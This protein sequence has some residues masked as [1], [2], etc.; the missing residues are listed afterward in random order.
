MCDNELIRPII[1]IFRL[2]RSMKERWYS[3]LDESG[4][5]IFWI[6]FL[7]IISL[8]SLL[9]EFTCLITLTWFTPEHTVFFSTEKAGNYAY[10]RLLLHYPS[11]KVILHTQSFRSRLSVI[12]T[13]TLSLIILVCRKNITLPYS[14]VV[15]SF[16]QRRSHRSHV[17]T[18][19]SVPQ[20]FS[21]DI[22]GL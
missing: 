1:S 9:S 4:I 12:H 20:R 14:L 22:L 5:F 17:C 21:R 13:L 19:Y 11:F 15:I 7:F 8:L 6:K 10:E 2:C 18:S 16:K 3:D